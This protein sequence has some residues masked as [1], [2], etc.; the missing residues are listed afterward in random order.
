MGKTTVEQAIYAEAYDGRLEGESPLPFFDSASAV[1]A[2]MDA[3]PG[4][5]NQIQ[6]AVETARLLGWRRDEISRIE[7]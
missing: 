2:W 7:P 5:G 4:P 3:H 1:L 6:V